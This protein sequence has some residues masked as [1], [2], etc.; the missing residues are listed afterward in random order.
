ML[1]SVCNFIFYNLIKNIK[2]NISETIVVKKVSIFNLETL[3]HTTSETYVK[4][5]FAII[6]VKYLSNELLNIGFEYT[7]S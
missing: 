7:T 4:I 6:S 2:N 5:S 3:L 1:F